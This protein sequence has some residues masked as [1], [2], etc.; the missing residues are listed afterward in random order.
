MTIIFMVKYIGDPE[1]NIEG[2]V[3]SREQF[4][5]WLR[6]RNIERV[7]Q[8]EVSEYADEFELVPLHELKKEVQ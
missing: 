6:E 5:E 2:Y 8:Q 3:H 4:L 1:E 7:R